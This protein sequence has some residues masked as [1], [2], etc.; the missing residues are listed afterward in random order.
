[1]R[2]IAN[3][4]GGLTRGFMSLFGSKNNQNTPQKNN[5][6]SIKHQSRRIRA[7]QQ[8]KYLAQYASRQ[9][10]SNAKPLNNTEQILAAKYFNHPSRSGS[11][12]QHLFNNCF[13]NCSGWNQ[14]VQIEERNER[15]EAILGS[16]S[17]I[18]VSGNSYTLKRNSAEQDAKVNIYQVLTDNNENEVSP[19]DIPFESYP[20][21]KNDINEENAL[22]IVPG[23]LLADILTF[24]G[25]QAAGILTGPLH[26]PNIELLLP[27]NKAASI[28]VWTNQNSE[29]DAYMIKVAERL[30]RLN[31]E[32]VNILYSKTPYYQ[33]I[34]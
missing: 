32:V 2:A 22:H 34:H 10:V 13:Y 9:A 3:F 24:H 31:F 11:I 15:I 16:E 30:K 1:M 23:T 6:I 29:I 20:L 18:E 19:L 5:L 12:P 25:H 27:L 4:F 8:I 26:I 14:L 17:E 33:T 21:Y 7:V 28:V